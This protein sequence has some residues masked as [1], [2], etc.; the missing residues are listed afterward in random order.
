MSNDLRKIRNRQAQR[1][2]KTPGGG[3]LPSISY[4]GMYLPIVLFWSE[5]GYTLCPFWSGIGYG[6][7][8]T[9]GVYERIYRFISNE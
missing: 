4:I 2:M 6:F 5:N 3:I 9:T 1:Q 8:G 7:E